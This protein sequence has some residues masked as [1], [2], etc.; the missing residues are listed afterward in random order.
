MNARHDGTNKQ[1][2]LVY[3]FFVG[4]RPQI[5]S[6]QKRLCVCECCYECDEKTDFVRRTNVH[7]LQHLLLIENTISFPNL[8][9]FRFTV[10]K[11]YDIQEHQSVLD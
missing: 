9:F 8:N 2:A 7:H 10:L 1:Q 3:E 11:N 4:P 6:L 5:T